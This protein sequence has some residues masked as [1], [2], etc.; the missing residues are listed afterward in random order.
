MFSSG[1][2]G[3]SFSFVSLALLQLPFISLVSASFHQPCFS[4]PSSALF[5][6]AFLLQHLLWSYLQMMSSLMGKA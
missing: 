6:L 2:E 1:P 4:F 3:F 5:Q